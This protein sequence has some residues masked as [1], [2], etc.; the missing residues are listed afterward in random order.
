MAGNSEISSNCQPF[1]DGNGFFCVLPNGTEIVTFD[2]LVF[3]KRDAQE[4]WTSSHCHLVPSP[5]E[6]HALSSISH[7]E[8]SQRQP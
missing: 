5:N 7:I 1:V 6:A 4:S 8:S 2:N 3:V